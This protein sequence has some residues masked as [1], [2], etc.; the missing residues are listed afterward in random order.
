MSS[1]I[2]GG[3]NETDA[4]S[5]CHKKRTATGRNPVAK[6]II[7]YKDGPVYLPEVLF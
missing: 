3:G 7:T 6:D 4:L 1:N 5:G 2:F